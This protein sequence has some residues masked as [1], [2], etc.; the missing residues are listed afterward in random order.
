MTADELQQQLSLS[1]EAVE[2]F[3]IYL[4]LLTKWQAK[5]NLVSKST[6]TDPWQRHVLDSAQLYPH[7]PEGAEQ[8]ADMGSGGGFPGMILAI[9]SATMGGPKVHLIESDQRKCVFLSEVNRQTTAGATIHNERVEAI[10]HLAVDVVTARACASVDKLLEMAAPLLNKNG[11]CLFLK[12]Q[13]VADELTQTDKRW[14]MQLQHIPS[15]SN[16]A[17]SILKIKGLCRSDAE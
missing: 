8:L 12:G 11:T 7:L 14:T 3:K 15:L 5:I 17:G 13:S 16:P 4:E 9:M 1:N 6:L 2:A 10:D